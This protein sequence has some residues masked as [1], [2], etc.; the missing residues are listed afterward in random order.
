MRG[1][2]KS[3]D[4]KSWKA[5]KSKCFFFSPQN[6]TPQSC[7]G[8]WR[9]FWHSMA[10]TFS[11]A[12]FKVSMFGFTVKPWEAAGIVESLKSLYLVY[13]PSRLEL[14]DKTNSTT[15]WKYNLYQKMIIQMISKNQKQNYVQT[16]KK[17]VSKGFFFFSFVLFFAVL[18]F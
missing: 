8:R 11:W 1:W 18:T 10:S 4:L 12:P 9:Y 7:K 16:T 5:T 3:A 2:L 17:W 6:C 14:L 13:W 15:E